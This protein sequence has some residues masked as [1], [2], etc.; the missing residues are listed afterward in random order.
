M[1]GY[2]MN[3]LYLNLQLNAKVINPCANACS[4]CLL[5]HIVFNAC[6]GYLNQYITSHLGLYFSTQ[7]YFT[8]AQRGHGFWQ[9]SKKQ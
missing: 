1:V 7:S 9:Q 8:E 5:K 3:M 6:I 2:N 4:K